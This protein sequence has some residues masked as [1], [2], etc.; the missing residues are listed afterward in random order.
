MDLSQATCK[1][2]RTQTGLSR[3]EFGEV[4]GIPAKTI[5]NWEQ[6]APEPKGAAVALFKILHML[7]MAFKLLQSYQQ[8]AQAEE[9]KD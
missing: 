2:V 5:R 7:P 3:Q 1:S 6:E 8:P 4:L 9:K